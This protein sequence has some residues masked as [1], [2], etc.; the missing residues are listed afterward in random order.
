MPLAGVCLWSDGPWPDVPAPEFGDRGRVIEVRE[1]T[2]RYGR[3]VAVDRL[4]FT[5]E[6]GQV[7]GFL[8]PNGAGKSTTMRVLLGLDAPDGGAALVNGRRYG[9]LRHPMREVGALLD[10][11][12]VQ[13]GRSALNHLRWM[14]RANR[15]GA[16][17]VTTMLERVGLAGVARKRIRTFSLGMKQRLGIAA[18]LLGD[19]GVLVFDEPVNGLDPDG[20]RWIRDLMRSLAGDGRTVLL[21]SHL[22]AEMALTA[23]RLIII[24]RGRMVADTSVKALAEQFHQGVLVKS[25]RS[26]ELSEALR[27]AGAA[28]TEEGAALSVTGLDVAAIGDLAAARG[29][30]LHEVTPRSASLE[31]AYLHL[32]GGVR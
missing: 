19:P 13:G 11:T 29:I 21:S 16:A 12:A 9:T 6:P 15:I 31:D 24:G 5:V 2:K 30:P 32:T 1:L 17:R 18:A 14:A 20:V 26:V 7:T 3:T 28:V 4:S 8:G 23:D 27:S 10:A 25:P 22:M